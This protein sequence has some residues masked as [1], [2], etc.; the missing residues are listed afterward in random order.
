MVELVRC[1]R[2]GAAAALLV[3]GA[4]SVPSAASGQELEPRAYA[5]LPIGLNFLLGGYAYTQGSLATDPALPLRDANLRTHTAVTAYARSLGV[6]GMS[7]KVDA[8]LPY[9]WLS[10]DATFAG[11]PR[12]REVSGFNDPR[13]R[14]TLNFYGAPAL[15]MEEFAS[16][17]Q[18]IIVGASLQVS[19]PLG[20]YDSSKLINL[21]TNRWFIKPELGISKAWGPLT[22][23]IAPSVTFYTKND[24]F[25]NGMTREQDPLYSLQG[26]LVY[27]F[28]RGIWGALDSTY[29]VGG[30]TEV[31]GVENDDRQENWRLGAT[32]SV[33]IGRRHSIKLYGSTGVSTRTGSDFDA[34]GLVWQY[35]WGH[36]L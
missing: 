24:D 2:G 17:E 30:S 18:D 4:M 9:S 23:E 26:H 19:V 3:A 33:P 21:G 36:G 14:F 32:L 16:Y 35:R 22:L 27:S 13:F 8:I 28:G 34:I 7:A 29:Y 20:Q 12:E 5:N 10:G 15:T 31:N 6:L 11:Q 25:L 1:W